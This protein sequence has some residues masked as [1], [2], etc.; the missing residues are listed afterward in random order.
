M[1]NYSSDQLD[2]IFKALS[3]STR[4]AILLQLTKGESSVSELAAPFNMSLAAISKH[5]KV[6]ES[7]NFVSKTKQGRNYRC[8]ANLEPLDGITDLLER[9]GSFWRQQLESLDEFLTNESIG[10]KKWKRSKKKTRP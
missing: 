1:V 6:L 3:D 8:T 5:L 4:R 2:S 7:A 9:L 10:D